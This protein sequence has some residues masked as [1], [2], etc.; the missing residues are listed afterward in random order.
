ML[1]RFESL[2]LCLANASAYVLSLYVCVPKAVRN[3]SRDAPKHIRYRSAAVS[4]ST[5]IQILILAWIYKSYQSTNNETMTSNTLLNNISFS[6]AMG[7]NCDLGYIFKSIVITTTL[8]SIFYVG[9]IVSFLLYLYISIHNDIGCD[10][11]CAPRGGGSSTGV[12]PLATWK[13]TLQEQYTVAQMVPETSMR[14]LL[15]API[16]EEIVFRAIMIVILLASISIESTN[17]TTHRDVHTYEMNAVPW[18]V[19][20]QCP[21]W[22]AVA[23][24]HHA[25]S[26]WMELSPT[27]SY[28]STEKTQMS[29]VPILSFKQ[30]M[31]KVG[32][33]TIIQLTYTTI[34]GYI[35]A[36]LF[37]RTGT[38]IAP[39]VSHMICNYA[40]LPDISFMYPA[41][42]SGHSS[43]YSCMYKHRYTLLLLHAGGLMV[44]T[45]MFMY[46]TEGM[47]V[48]APFWPTIG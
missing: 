48:T 20:M 30:K 33:P 35:A 19:A 31:M 4:A 15:V 44:F 47:S 34:F 46:M 45:V 40:Q 28:T 39:I 10:G 25:Y 42:K 3:L 27:Q 41:G 17:I 22:F 24:F 37:L 1:S 16:T 8:M 5:V 13:K 7:M 11:I 38:L 23:H 21:L 29:N 14:A 43:E 36:L 9:P 2:S 12:S 26:R 32:M 6:A 18:S